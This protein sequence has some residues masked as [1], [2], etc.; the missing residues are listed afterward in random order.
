MAAVC[1]VDAGLVPAVYVQAADMYVRVQELV[2]ELSCVVMYV[3]A[4]LHI[5]YGQ[6]V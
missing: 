6:A 4:A 5:I 3:K 1:L 2:R